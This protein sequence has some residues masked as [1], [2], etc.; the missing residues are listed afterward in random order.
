MPPEITRRVRFLR[1]YEV[2]DHAAGTER[3]RR[4]KAGK[5][6]ELTERSAVHFINRGL[7]EPVESGTK[8]KQ[9]E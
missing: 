4:Y 5:T 1:D 9:G 2:Q 7:A 3:A 8:A 6:V